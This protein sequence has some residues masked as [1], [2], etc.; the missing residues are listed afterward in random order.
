MLELP[1]L[2]WPVL[3]LVAL[4]MGFVA[5]RTNWCT[6]SAVAEIMTEGRAYILWRVT[7]T[8]LWIIGIT[9]LIDFFLKVGL[10]RL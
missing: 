1:T 6:A 5:D 4:L 8:V 9:T 7:K 2:I 3:F 10:L